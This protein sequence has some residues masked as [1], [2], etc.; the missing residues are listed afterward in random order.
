MRS[1][2]R[3]SRKGAGCSSKC[4]APILLLSNTSLSRRIME[5]ADSNTAST[6]SR[7]SAVKSLW[8]SM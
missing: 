7:W 8:A 3:S 2:S 5:C 6:H 1:S 4:P